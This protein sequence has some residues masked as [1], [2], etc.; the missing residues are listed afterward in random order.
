MTCAECLM[1]IETGPVADI[2]LSDDV[3][4][5]VDSCQHCSHAVTIIAEAERELA[6]FLASAASEIP[7]RQTAENAVAAA[8]RRAAGKMVAGGMIVLMMLALW[9]TWIRVIAPGVR[10]TQALVKDNNVTV[11]IPLTCLSSQQAGDLISPYVRSNGSLYWVAKPPMRF[12]S[13]RATP[14]ELQTARALI[15]Q[16][17]R[18]GS[19]SCAP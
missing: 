15:A 9:F 6:V 2:V 14:E 10:D 11:T 16:F 19:T 4:L 7:A 13:V 3:R 12:I 1:L 5:H 17:D 8:T 18:P